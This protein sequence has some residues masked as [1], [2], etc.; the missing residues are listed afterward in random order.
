MRYGVS[1]LDS[2]VTNYIIH[3]LFLVDRRLQGYWDL[4]FVL[5]LIDGLFDFE[6]H[7][8]KNIGCTNY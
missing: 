5:L 6:S 7:I 8:K 2:H 4:S 3:G 1:R